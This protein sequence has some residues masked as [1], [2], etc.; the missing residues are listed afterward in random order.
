MGENGYCIDQEYLLCLS[1]NAYV[2][3][4]GTTFA[5]PHCL[6]CLVGVTNRTKYTNLICS[7]TPPVY[8][9]TIQ[10]LPKVDL[11][12]TGICQDDKAGNDS[13]LDGLQKCIPSEGNWEKHFHKV[14]LIL[15]TVG[16][17]GSI[18]TLCLTITTY[19]MFKQLMTIPGKNLVSLCLSI[20]I[21]DMIILITN[22][23]VLPIIMCKIFG[24]LLHW[25]SLASQLWGLTI[26]FDLYK[27]F[28]SNIMAQHE[29]RF[30]IYAI[31]NWTTTTIVATACAA[32]GSYGIIPRYG[33]APLCFLTSFKVRIAA[34][35]APTI[36]CL[37]VSIV[38]GTLSICNIRRTK[39][40]SKATLRGST[41]RRNTVNMRALTTRIVLM[42]GF[43]EVLGFVQVP[44]SKIVNAAEIVN[45]A[46]GL[47]Y[48][49][50]RSARGLLIFFSF[51]FRR[52]IFDM[53]RQR[54]HVFTE[55]KRLSSLTET[56]NSTDQNIKKISTTTC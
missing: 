28:R 52:N 31:I 30:K 42:L 10:I 37:L 18:I 23:Y 38:L 15:S 22:Y 54:V 35:I 16:T 25:S 44:N 5:N 20:L 29:N 13:D 21:S 17:T 27:T 32:T 12:I 46:F 33:R 36:F 19:L 45:A 3:Y 1:Y 41:N 8:Q 56:K 50:T 7:I 11:E 26:V 2:W 4:N 6:R 24:A 43:V 51:V 55:S 48:E 49:V 9:G 14:Q 53:Y 34:F 39:K 40:D 47:L